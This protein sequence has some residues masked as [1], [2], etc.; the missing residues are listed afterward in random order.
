MR[1]RLLSVLVVAA[2]CGPAAAL[3]P[4]APARG[5]VPPLRVFDCGEGVVLLVRARAAGDGVDVEW[6]DRRPTLARVP[7]EDETYAGTGVTL[8]I[9]AAGEEATLRGDGEE[10]LACRHG[11]RARTLERV[12]GEGG[13][14]WAVGNEPGWMLELYPERLVFVGDYGE[15]RYDG[16]IAEVLDEGGARRYLGLA[17]GRE[18]VV[19]V[20]PGLCRDVM[21]GAAFGAEVIVTREGDEFR[22]CGVFLGA[23]RA[24]E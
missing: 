22:G 3:A 2:A 15:T 12:A 14:V 5:S 21:S 16:T 23:A 18:T 9:D 13:L 1:L 20:T 17:G 4:S 7:G 19:R 8:A 10:P 24:G 11:E 6:G